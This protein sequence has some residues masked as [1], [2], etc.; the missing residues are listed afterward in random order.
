MI[1]ANN[2][3]KYNLVA[4]YGYLHITIIHYYHSADLCMTRFVEWIKSSVFPQNAPCDISNAIVSYVQF[5]QGC[6][7]VE[8]VIM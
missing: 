2:R 1:C 7:I 8:T 6:Q 3:V 5:L 4:V